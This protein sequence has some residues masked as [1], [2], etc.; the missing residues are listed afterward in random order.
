MAKHKVFFCV[1]V[2][3][4][5]AVILAVSVI[6]PI[7]EDREPSTLSAIQAS[8][9]SNAD[10]RTLRTSAAYKNVNFERR[11]EMNQIETRL[12]GNGILN[13]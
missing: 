1:S 9:L 8:P 3:L 6:N 10:K 4:L 12:A 7:G 5:I 11:R 13:R 2:L